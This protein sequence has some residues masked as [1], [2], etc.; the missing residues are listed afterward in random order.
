MPPKSAKGGS[1]GASKSKGDESGDK[2][3]EKK[4]GTAV[5][6]RHI[7]CEKQGKCL[8]ALEK[9]KAGQNFLK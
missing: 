8:E 4:G 3:K 5:K 9:L 7:L 6:V 1:K 2:S